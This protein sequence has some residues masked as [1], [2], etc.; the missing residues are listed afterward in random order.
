MDKKR[1]NLITILA[2]IVVIV[3]IVYTA[4]NKISDINF[5][6]EMA[7]ELDEISLEVP[8][9]FKNDNLSYALAYTYNND[10]AYCHIYVDATKK[11][12]YD[13]MSEWFNKRVD[14]NL[15][16][17]LSEL[18][19]KEINGNKIRYIS[20]KGEYKEVHYYGLESSNYYYMINYSI[21]NEDTITCLNFMESILDSIKLK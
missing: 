2:V 16:D 12:Y 15:S 17:E 7:K 6:K 20:K 18:T 4:Y 19:T 11:T 14:F 10:E 5:E 1:K 8:D 21:D 3:I 9:G 13:S